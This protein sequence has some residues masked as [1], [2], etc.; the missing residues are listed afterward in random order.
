LMRRRAPVARS[1]VPHCVLS[2][3]ATGGSPRRERI[4]HDLIARLR[5]KCIRSLRSK[6]QQRSVGHACPDYKRM[7]VEESSASRFPYR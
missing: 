2:I 6:Q 1:R 5:I 7:V 3:S 4:A